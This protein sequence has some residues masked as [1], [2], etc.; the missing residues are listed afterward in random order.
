MYKTAP[1]LKLLLQNVHNQ[2]AQLETIP[3]MRKTTEVIVQCLLQL[4][5]LLQN[6]HNQSAQLETSP[7]MRENYGSHC[8]MFVVA[9]T[10]A[11][12]CT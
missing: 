3:K 12:E 9:H 8:P 4:T 2:S 6:V 10:I 1:N 7:K 11:T 5:L